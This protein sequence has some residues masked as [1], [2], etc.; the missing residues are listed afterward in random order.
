[1]AMASGAD[2]VLKGELVVL[3]PRMRQLGRSLAGTKELADELVQAAC[4]RAL[5]R[6][7]QL[8]PGTRVD[9]WLFAIMRSIWSNELRARRVRLGGGLVDADT[10]VDRPVE[11]QLEARL[12]LDKIDGILADLPG[13]QRAV[14]R[15]VCV[16][17]RSYREA[18]EALEIPLGTLMSRLAR[19]RGVIAERLNRAGASASRA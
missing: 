17:G 8:E 13:E 2:A 12:T 1:M 5:Q 18:A 10:L 14:L 6:F 16:E 19:G 9:H 15:L 11:S 4:E 7:H 3:L